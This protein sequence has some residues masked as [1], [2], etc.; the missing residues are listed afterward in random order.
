MPYVANVTRCP[1][2]A[3]KTML[4]YQAL[5]EGESKEVV[6]ELKNNSPKMMMVEVVPP[7]FQLSGLIVNPSVI[8]MAPGRMAL[9]SLRYSAAFRD[10]TASGLADMNK[11]KPKATEG[12][13]EEGMPKGL[14]AKNKKLAERL[15]KKKNEVKDAAAPIDPKKKG[16]PAPA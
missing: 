2:Q 8:P 15:E 6:I 3:D 7:N 9:V 11:P 16:A 10:L 12:E 13:N 14:V 1:V 5:P 4:E